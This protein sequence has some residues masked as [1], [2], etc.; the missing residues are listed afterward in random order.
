MRWWTFVFVCVL[1]FSARNAAAQWTSRP[2][3]LGGYDVSGPGGQSWS[4]SRNVF[5]GLNW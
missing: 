1:A 2:N 3:V 5:G 4:S